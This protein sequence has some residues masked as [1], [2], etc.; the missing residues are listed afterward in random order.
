M[1]PF[2]QL[3][4]SPKTIASFSGWCSPH[5]ET[6]YCWFDT[7]LEIEDVVVPGLVLHG[8]CYFHRPDCHVTLELRIAKHAGRRCRPLARVDWRSLNGPHSND[9]RWGPPWGGKQVPDTHIHPFEL[10]WSSDRQRMKSSNLPIACPIEPP[11]NDFNKLREFAGKQ[12][13][14][15]NIELVS[16]PDWEYHLL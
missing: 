1:H 14:I 16:A 5:E 4:D 9:R 12:F 8:G 13:R 3:A 10:N 7:P 15:S 6:G 11:P 2:P